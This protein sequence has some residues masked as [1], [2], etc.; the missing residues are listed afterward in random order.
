MQIIPVIDLMGGI[1]VQAG[2]GDRQHY[3]PLQSVL[4]QHTEP[5]KVIA[6]LRSGL[7]FEIIYIADLDGIFYQNPDIALYKHLVKVFPELVFWIDSGIKSRQDW[8]ELTKVSGVKP[9]IASETLDD[10]TLLEEAKQSILSLDFQDECFLGKS[11]IWQYS[12]WWPEMVI[13]MNLDSI[14]SQAGPDTKLLQQIRNKR[15]DVNIIAAGGV[16][17]LQDLLML[18]REY[19][20]GALV[21][22]ALHNGSLNL[23]MLTQ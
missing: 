14:G 23:R 9:V 20:S 17:S 11:E 15:S 18:E 22:S 8:Q 5:E 13:A 2:G 16:R 7:S 21:A 10:L 1:V 6:D 4:T 12:E 3:P 19:I